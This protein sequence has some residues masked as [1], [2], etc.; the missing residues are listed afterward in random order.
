MRRLASDR[1]LG[2][3]DRH[4]PDDAGG[5]RLR[6]SRRGDGEADIRAL[7]GDIRRAATLFHTPR[8]DHDHLNFLLP[9][10]KAATDDLRASFA[11]FS[12]TTRKLPAGD[13]RAPVAI[14]IAA[15]ARIR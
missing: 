10:T 12:R 13:D 7:A 9:E 15:G 8:R 14:E 2:N 4:L 3:L 5:P 6:Q 1:S 11:E